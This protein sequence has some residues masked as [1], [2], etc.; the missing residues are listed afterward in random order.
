MISAPPLALR[1]TRR[2]FPSHILTAGG[3]DLVALLHID[4]SQ[5]V[6]SPVESPDAQGSI[7]V[8]SSNQQNGLTSPT[9]AISDGAALVGT[10]R[11][12]TA[13]RRVR[14]CHLRA[15]IPRSPR[16]DAPA[17][18]GGRHVPRRGLS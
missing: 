16:T 2:Q 17:G 11:S 6:K 7:A 10:V 12:L 1:R 18:P 13:R 9:T 14:L 4:V 5:E 8:R 15:E 3:L